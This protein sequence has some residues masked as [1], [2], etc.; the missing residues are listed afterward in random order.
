MLCG[1]E[2]GLAFEE[3]MLRETRETADAT[4]AGVGFRRGG[5]AAGPE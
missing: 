3:D 5:E 1:E 2:G 4:V